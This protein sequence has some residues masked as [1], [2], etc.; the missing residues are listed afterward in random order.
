MALERNNREMWGRLKR[1][2]DQGRQVMTHGGV[3]GQVWRSR[4]G[5]QA[6]V[7]RALR[8]VEVAPLDAALGRMSGRLLA[9]SGTSDV[10]DAALISLAEEGD[11]IATSDALD[12][13]LLVDATDI[14][15]EIVV[16]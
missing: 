4:S 2:N 3:V 14:D 12:L 8:G 5:E 1:A 16:T 10:I 15:V 11:Q 6:L 13:L 9:I 7:A